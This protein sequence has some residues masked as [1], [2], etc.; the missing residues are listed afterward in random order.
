[1]VPA[2]RQCI[3]KRRNIC[4][5]ASSN[6]KKNLPVCQCIK[7]DKIPASPDF[8]I[9]IFLV[10]MPLNKIP[11]NRLVLLKSC[12]SRAVGLAVISYTVLD[13]CCMYRELSS[14]QHWSFDMFYLDV[15]NENVQQILQQDYKLTFTFKNM[16]NLTVVN[17]EY[18]V[19]NT[20]VR[21]ARG[22]WQKQEW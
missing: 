21:R 15:C 12:Q 13:N 19:R 20:V 8:K 4:W 2:R 3:S 7:R 18:S 6:S 9:W 16:W 10:Y 5:T 17:S 11:A 22:K 1:M 14:I